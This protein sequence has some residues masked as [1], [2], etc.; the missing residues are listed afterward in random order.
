VGCN[1]KDEYSSEFKW[2]EYSYN[3]AAKKVSES[4]D[5]SQ[6]EDKKDKKRKHIE[7]KQESSKK[8]IYSRFE[9]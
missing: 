6:D 3:R 2:W 1:Q 5:Q 8:S 7:D 4:L 9:K